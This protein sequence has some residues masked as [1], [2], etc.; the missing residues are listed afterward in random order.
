MNIIQIAKDNDT[1]DGK[2]TSDIDDGDN[3]GDAD[4]GDDAGD[5]DDDGEGIPKQFHHDIADSFDDDGNPPQRTTILTAVNM[6]QPA[7]MPLSRRTVM[8]LVENAQN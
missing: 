2:D 7:R 3:A 5:N 1:I 6:K 4:D 8:S